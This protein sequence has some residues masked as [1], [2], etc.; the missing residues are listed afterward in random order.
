MIQPKPFHTYKTL[1][2]VDY[3]K[4]L[5]V[6]VGVDGYIMTTRDNLHWKKRKNPAGTGILY[7]VCTNGKI[8]M[9]CGANGIL[10]SVDGEKWEHVF[11]TACYGIKTNGKSFV[12]L[13]NSSN[14][15]VSDDNGET[16]NSYAIGSSGLYAFDYINDRFVRVS[17]SYI[18]ISVDGKIWA[19]SANSHGYSTYLQNAHYNNYGRGPILWNEDRQRYM[20]FN[21]YASTYTGNAGTTI[22]HT[23]T[24]EYDGN[25][26]ITESLGPSQ[27][28]YGGQA[29]FERNF[30]VGKCHRLKD[31]S[32]IAFQTNGHGFIYLKDSML[33]YCFIQ[34]RFTEGYILDFYETDEGDVITVGT[35][36]AQRY[37]FKKKCDDDYTHANTFQLCPVAVDNFHYPILSEAQN[38]DGGTIVRC[39]ACIG[40]S[41][42]VSTNGGKT[43]TKASTPTLRSDV[44]WV[45]KLGLFISGGQGT[46]DQQILTSPNGFT[47]ST[48]A[49]GFTASH[50][51]KNIQWFPEANNG[52]GVIV[53]TNNHGEIVTSPDGVTWTKRKSVDS[54]YNVF[55]IART[56]WFDNPEAEAS[57]LN[58]LPSEGIEG[59]DKVYH[60]TNGDKYY[61][62]DPALNNNAGG[63]KEITEV[64]KYICAAG[65]GNYAAWSKDLISW[66]TKGVPAR[67]IDLDVNDKGVVVATTTSN[68]TV[69]V[70][71]NRTKWS[72]VSKTL[73]RSVGANVVFDPIK[74]YF[75]VGGYNN[76]NANKYFCFSKNGINWKD[77]TY[78]T[79]PYADGGANSGLT[80]HIRIRNGKILWYNSGATDYNI[81]S[82]NGNVVHANNYTVK[83]GELLP[84]TFR[85][86]DIT[87]K[88]EYLTNSLPDDDPQ[89]LIAYGDGSDRGITGLLRSIHYNDG[90]YFAASSEGVWTSD[91]DG[92]SWIKRLSETGYYAFA[93]KDNVV[94]ALGGATGQT[95]YV[96]SSADN[97]NTWKVSSATSGT[98]AKFLWKA[99]TNGST[100][101]SLAHKDVSSN[102]VY[103]APFTIDIDVNSWTEI[104]V[105]KVLLG[106]T[107]DGNEFIAVGNDGCIITSP[108]AVAW[109]ERT[110]GVTTKLNSVKK[111]SNRY[112]AVGDSGKLLIS[113]DKVTWEA[114]NVKYTGNIEDITKLGDTIFLITPDVDNIYISEDMGETWEIQEL[115]GEQTPPSLQ[116]VCERPLETS[117]IACNHNVDSSLTKFYEIQSRP[118]PPITH[119][120]PIQVESAK[121]NIKW[122]A[123]IQGTSAIRGYE[124]QRKV[125]QGIWETIYIGSAPSSQDTVPQYTE[126][127]KIQYRVRALTFDL[128]EEASAWTLTNEI[129]I[130]KVDQYL[131]LGDDEDIGSYKMNKPSFT[132]SI[133]LETV[134]S[135]VIRLINEYIDNTLIRSYEPDT[136]QNTVTV[137]DEAWVKVLNGNHIF[138]IEAIGENGA[139]NNQTISFTKNVDKIIFHFNVP[140]VSIVKPTAI[141]VNVNKTASKN[142]VFLV[143]A[144]NNGFDSNPAWEDIT[145]YVKK[146]T[147]APLQNEQKESNSWGIDIKVTFDRA[148]SQGNCNIGSLNGNFG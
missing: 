94:F 89:K 63:Y 50:V 26:Y 66:T 21:Y 30:Q 70:L 1:I 64:M 93:S 77:T 58:L 37:S 2:A 5:A 15:Y 92:Y 27:T 120:I 51:C 126:A 16:W 39:V 36:G 100:I 107:Y 35:Q 114:K 139:S 57:T 115:Y 122:S 86:T 18:D 47:W 125:D 62:W 85:P 44:I 96:G 87:G 48:V 142:S 23:G 31:G 131:P 7:D 61:Q 132:Y 72:W 123:S 136:V 148:S 9:A 84:F 45:S 14:S 10:R 13:N 109:T 17:S 20:T 104:T 74:K 137:T 99:A 110:S 12:A 49:S 116:F 8:W 42:V 75:I 4:G 105:P 71:E 68:S 128:N 88:H 60:V 112:F 118:N 41:V 24:C 59:I 69:Y 73:N 117:T 55:K 95:R 46:A 33:R 121:L 11:S 82:N 102:K 129:Q 101:C 78:P 146:E 22:F 103:I 6:A 111:Y 53:A 34:D 79:F 98:S 43:W 133:E 19:R 143:E 138:R 124:L 29:F 130:L 80:M 134:Q 108:D 140:L 32:H 113:V 40:S 145:E 67:F 97:G 119:T 65:N 28:T 81:Y 127:Q 147:V 76:G 38:D 25:Q 144:C 91:D 52:N 141:K 83:S 56:G 90:R 3:S 106:I 135:G 54:G